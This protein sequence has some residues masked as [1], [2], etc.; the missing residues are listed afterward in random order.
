MENHQLL[1]MKMAPTSPRPSREESKEPVAQSLTYYFRSHT[2][3]RKY[4]TRTKPITICFGAIPAKGKGCSKE[5]KNAL[6]KDL[7]EKTAHHKKKL[8]TVRTEQKELKKK[9]EKISKQ[10]DCTEELKEALKSKIECNSKILEQESIKT[11]LDIPG[12]K[13]TPDLFQ[14]YLHT[15]K[16]CYDL[17][18]LP[19][20][21]VQIGRMTKEIED[22][23]KSL[24]KIY[25]Y[26]TE[27]KFESIMKDLLQKDYNEATIR[28]FLNA[29]IKPFAQKY[30]L[31]LRLEEIL[32]KP[33]VK[34]VV[35]GNISDYTIYTSKGEILGCIEAK[36][37]C[38]LTEH[39]IQ[40]MLQLI[41]LR[42]RSINTLFTILTD[43][44][45]FAFVIYNTDDTFQF[46]T[47]EI[48]T[49]KK[50]K[51]KKFKMHDVCNFN[52]LQEVVGIVDASIKEGKDEIRASIHPRRK[53]NRKEN[54]QSL[55]GSST[56][57]ETTESK[58][59]EKSSKV[60]SNKPSTSSS[61]KGSTKGK[62][63]KSHTPDKV[64]K[65]KSCF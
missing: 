56:A 9:L 17:Q 50:K 58:R 2:S 18:L 47:H 8:K 64:K 5:F 12:S 24:G 62:G 28:L 13:W 42:E 60:E 48:H 20:K 35:P 52:G 15:F 32:E 29:F 25:I 37:N 61:S 49:T 19:S 44:N 57:C 41:S 46:E 4:A 23:Y 54:E 45:K 43:V 33:G 11:D 40:C 65:S 36:A 16:I 3:P 59:R 26:P 34:R 27:D 39:Y 14:K 7:K 63:K 21:E 51:T 30:D 55:T 38:G 10:A 1:L 22:K 31:Q 6:Q 53:G